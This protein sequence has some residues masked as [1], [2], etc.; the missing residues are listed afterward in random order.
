MFDGNH[1]VKRNINTQRRNRRNHRR[2]SST[3]TS[4]STNN[5][6]TINASLNNI[7]NTKAELLENAKRLRHERIRKQKE[8]DSASVIQKWYRGFRARLNLM[9]WL[10]GDD[11]LDSTGCSAGSVGNAPT[12]DIVTF[13][14]RVGRRLSPPLVPFLTMA[15][16]RRYCSRYHGMQMETTVGTSGN[17]ITSD[18]TEGGSRSTG[19][20]S[21]TMEECLWNML[22][23]LQKVVNL[24]QQSQQQQQSTSD[25]LRNACSKTQQT[26][27]FGRICYRLIQLIHSSCP[28]PTTTTT[29]RR[30][31]PSPH[32]SSSSRG[33][34]NDDNDSVRITSLVRLMEYLIELWNGANSTT[35]TT[36][37]TATT[38]GSNMDGDINCQLEFF[39]SIWTL[40]G[41]VVPG[42]GVGVD[43]VLPNATKE[44]ARNP[45]PVK[46]NGTA[47][48][49]HYS[50]GEIILMALVSCF[51]DWF[52]SSL[53]VSSP[54]SSPP[55]DT[56]TDATYIR[57]VATKLLQWTFRASVSLNLINHDDDDDYALSLLAAVVLCTSDLKRVEYSYREPLQDCFRFF[58]R[59]QRTT[60]QIIDSTNSL[61]SSSS[62]SIVV[63][64][65]GGGELL[66]QWYGKLIQSMAKILIT[67]TTA[68]TST[69]PMATTTTTAITN[70][71]TNTHHAR[72]RVAI[73]SQMVRSIL[74]HGRNV[75]FLSNALHLFP[76]TTPKPTTTTTSRGNTSTTTT[77]EE[78]DALS[79]TTLQLLNVVLVSNNN[80]NNSTSSSTITN[81]TNNNDTTG[82]DTSQ[83]LS[84]LCSLAAKGDDVTQLLSSL[85]RG[86]DVAMR[87]DMANDLDGDT[88][89]DDD[90]G[91]LDD[92]DTMMEGVVEQ[93]VVSPAVV[94]NSHRS[95]VGLQRGNTN[96]GGMESS[97]LKRRA[98]ARRQ[99]LQTISKL[100]QLYQ[101]A[102]GDARRE[103]LILLQRQMIIGKSVG[104]GDNR[105]TSTIGGGGGIGLS[106]ESSIKLLGR[107]ATDVGGG[108]LL[109]RLGSVVFR[110]GIS[111]NG[112]GGGLTDGYRSLSL[113]RDTYVRVLSN[114][115]QFCTGTKSK[116]S[117][118]SPLLSKLAFHSDLLEELW[119]YAQEQLR[120]AS[121]SSSSSSSSK[122]DRSSGARRNTR[123]D[124]NATR[125]MQI[126]KAY[127][128]MLVFSD[129]FSQQLLAL[130]DEEFLSL[131]TDHNQNAIRGSPTTLIRAKDIIVAMRD[132]LYDLY[133]N[134]PVTASEIAVPSR[135][136]SLDHRR[137]MTGHYDIETTE[138]RCQRG[139]LLLS[140]TKLWNSLY[141]R[142][143]R[144]YRSAKFCGEECWLFPRLV[145]HSRDEEGAVMNSMAAPEDDNDDILDMDVDD[146][147]DSLPMNLDDDVGR[148]GGAGTG[149]S[150]ATA[151]DV[152]NDAMASSF[153][154][155]KMARILTCIPQALPFDRRV[156][157]F[158]SLREADMARTQDETQA[159][160]DMMMN[161]Q[162][163]D[164][165]ASFMGREQVEIRRASMY[166][167]A[168]EHLNKLGRNL[169][170]RVQVTFVNQHGTRE[171]GIDGGGVFK[172]FLDDLIKDAFDP[173]AERVSAFHPLFN[174]TPLQTLRVND[175]LRTSREVLSHYEFL[176]RV[177]GK[178]V[179]ESILVEPQFCLP[180]LNQ[181][182]GKQNT[183]DDLKNVDPE[184]HRQLS[185]VRRMNESDIQGMGLSFELTMR[186]N[187]GANDTVELIP[188][189]STMLVTK[190]NTIRYVH[191]V[192]HR[193][194]NIETAAQTLA[195]LRGFRDLIP[196]AWVR[197]F[198]PY[199]LQKLIG[200][201][202]SVKGFNVKGL[203]AVMMYG[204]GYHPTQA[205][206]QW[207]WEVVEE[208]SP[209]RQRKLLKFITSCSRQ[210]L[211][212][213]GALS[214]KPCIQQVR[215][216]E[217]NLTHEA[218]RNVKLPTSST[219]MNLLKLPN[220]G[221]KETLK[222]KLL[223][224][225]ESGAGFELS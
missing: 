121:L 90:M 182:L 225:V 172:E 49:Q 33:G 159:L 194:L 165:D 132:I 210:P 92:A 198:S 56:T 51:K 164:D 107:I 174:A 221:T 139:R 173:E 175:G 26:L 189:G 91:D 216:A 133:W 45:K 199:E 162:R 15:K 47:N 8:I 126:M 131:Y 69:P 188:G 115:L 61:T 169:R 37:T 53:T 79:F 5:T 163:G 157:L 46:P 135:Y 114:V 116:I 60:R 17:T 14:R 117:A 99:D 50:E 183:L 32:S 34:N 74:S 145:T 3:S 217:E 180:F 152:E 181:L 94:S 29:T 214:P 71:N 39:Q 101:S 141:E 215:L 177:L 179:Y 20:S 80:N 129:L 83:M 168:M 184:Y 146:D 35:A 19:G 108:G 4:T 124:N 112:G 193:R 7:P 222:Q 109:L 10:D 208:M 144:L 118:M 153:R 40:Q 13:I 95:S 77:V 28:N 82:G 22:L 70:T 98:I 149:A 151:V 125:S 21:I 27:V 148:A 138:E 186:R 64:G 191:L 1:R 102:I 96:S 57:T 154:D 142:W 201:D 65:E 9:L 24:S 36:T 137:A 105:T 171:A 166:E 211:L 143:S 18:A 86:N 128:A 196:A 6:R 178:A 223:Y 68:L 11:W 104:V 190:K 62:S 93:D 150:Q 111:L 81:S 55:T 58:E 89:A 127:T 123:Y 12:M 54:S 30:Q 25:S 158:N 103:A 156:K 202:D 59:Q 219:C 106:S 67:D 41:V 42:T 97:R 197:L 204:G 195:F 136:L 187:D 218:G 212:G 113:A 2:D 161:M 120:K 87:R 48:G 119:L 170:K 167:D 160:R 155:P 76:T 16:R 110:K 44:Y 192:A 224:A 66:E 84:V 220:Y 209:D 134:R 206:M 75:L 88:Y 43:S 185:A 205:I 63:G 130:D 100:D 38:H 31:R 23:T 140:G 85:A 176:G 207:F 73:L 213:F 203:K 72:R 78:Q 200:G 147:D 122:I 52:W